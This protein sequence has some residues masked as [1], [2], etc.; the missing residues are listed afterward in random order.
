MLHN[1]ET[2]MQQTRMTIVW[3]LDSYSVTGA[4]TQARLEL[5]T[6]RRFRGLFG[7]RS[8]AHASARRISRAIE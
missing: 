4:T 3:K 1:S 6:A 2:S 5:N 8:G 7:D